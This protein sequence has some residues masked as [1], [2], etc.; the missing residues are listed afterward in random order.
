MLTY[1]TALVCGLILALRK[2]LLILGSRLGDGIRDVASDLRNVSIGPALL[3][4]HVSEGINQR[5]TSLCR[6]S[7]T[8][9]AASDG[10]AGPSMFAQSLKKNAGNSLDGK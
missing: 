10:P 6:V 9:A 5:V 1:V 3:R 4:G 8:L 2:T 7:L